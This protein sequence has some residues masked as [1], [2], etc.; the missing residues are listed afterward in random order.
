MITRMVYAFLI[1][2]FLGY[3]GCYQTS[4]ITRDE[5][6]DQASKAI[7]VF[8]VD[9]QHLRF[10]E[11]QYN[12]KADTLAGIGAPVIKDSLGGP[13]SRTIPLSDIKK[14]E[15]RKFN[16]PLLVGFVAGAV[17]VGGTYAW[18]SKVDWKTGNIDGNS[19]RT[20]WEWNWGW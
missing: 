7:D 18:L 11:E 3:T 17:I 15:V 8:T 9:S 19:P 1:F 4:Q 20:K 2:S 14:I 6:G 12:I 10:A 5:L 16:T 13:C